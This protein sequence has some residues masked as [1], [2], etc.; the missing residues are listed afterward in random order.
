MCVCVCVCARARARAHIMA[1]MWKSND[2]LRESVLSSHC[3]IPR[4]YTCAICLEGKRL[5]P[6]IN[7]H[8]IFFLYSNIYL[9]RIHAGSYRVKRYFLLSG[10]S[11]VRCRVYILDLTETLDNPKI[12]M[13][14]VL[15]SQ[16]QASYN[17]HH[18]IRSS[19]LSDIGR[20]KWVF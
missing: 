7:S 18:K 4:D 10:Q 20:H 13:N 5:Y 17:S 14:E 11:K 19:N 9:E 1:C 15:H 12:Y 16:V 2:N 3:M 8:N 6:L